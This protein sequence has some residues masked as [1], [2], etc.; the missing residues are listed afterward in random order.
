MRQNRCN[1]F[2]RRQI[3][4]I[5]HRLNTEANL[6]DHDGVVNYSTIWGVPF[7]VETQ[8]FIAAKRIKKHRA[9]T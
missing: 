4:R 9:D 2:Q 1:S 5:F 3:E 6:A 7:Q 8:V